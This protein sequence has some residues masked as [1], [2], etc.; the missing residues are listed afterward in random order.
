MTVGIKECVE[1]YAK[2][3]GISKAQAEVEFRTALNVITDMCIEGGVSF[4][5]LF[6]IKKKLRKGRTGNINGNTW[7]TKDTNVLAIKTG[8]ILMEKLNK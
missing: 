8:N 6:T 2:E 4:K 5:G 7:E 1:L 3:R